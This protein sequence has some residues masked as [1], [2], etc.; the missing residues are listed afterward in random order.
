[1]AVKATPKAIELLE[2]AKEEKGEELTKTEAVKTAGP[3]YI[4]AVAVCAAS[5]LCIFG[6]NVLNKKKQASLAGAYALLNQSYKRYR[7]AAKTVYGEDADSKI[8]AQIAE[9]RYISADGYALLPDSDAAGENILFYDEWSQRYFTSTMA[10]VINA[11]YHLNRNLNLR[12]EAS[13]NE[14]YEFLG[15]DKIDGGD[16]LVWDMEELVVGGVVWLDF[17]NRKVKM[18]DGMECY[19]VTAVYGP[20]NTF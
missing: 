19:M 7:N 20:G 17:V 18:E 9:D 3:V 14:F 2:K 5:I 4:P 13:L 10:A 1:M 12:G 16:D 11:Q 6:A 15:I 8:Q